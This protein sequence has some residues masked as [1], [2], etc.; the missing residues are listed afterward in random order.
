MDATPAGMGPGTC[1]KEIDG[2][3]SVIS[4]SGM[5]MT[6]QAWQSRV[7]LLTP[8]LGSLLMCSLRVFGWWLGLFQPM[9]SGWNSR[10]VCQREGRPHL[11][12]L[13]SGPRLNPLGTSP[14][15]I[16]DN[17]MSFSSCSSHNLFIQLVLPTRAWVW[18][19]PPED[20]EPASGHSLEENRFL[21]Q[22][23]PTV[24]HAWEWELMSLSP[25]LVG[26]LTDLTLTVTTTDV[27][28]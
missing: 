13:E 11:F 24:N 3:H 21:L 15:A 23:S 18:N 5:L 2:S 4:G 22:Q 16:Q 8:K 12:S 27:S 25:A 14:S 26:M 10:Q 7:C 6:G 9:T 17:F 20:G 19:R 28:L 1:G